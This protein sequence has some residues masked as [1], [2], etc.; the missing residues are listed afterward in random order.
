MVMDI[1]IPDEPGSD[2][3]LDRTA[4]VELATVP[5]PP[6]ADDGDRTVDPR[7]AVS[8]QPGSRQPA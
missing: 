6:L 8:A 3:L 4:Q 5:A 1:R 7:R 2:G